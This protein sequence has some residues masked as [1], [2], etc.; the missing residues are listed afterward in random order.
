MDTIVRSF[1]SALLVAIVATSSLASGA[2]A[3]VQRP[4]MGTVAV[5]AIEDASDAVP[6]VEEIRAALIAF[7]APTIN[8]MDPLPSMPLGD[9]FD[10]SDRYV[11]VPTADSNEVTISVGAYNVDDG[12]DE[13][14]EFQTA[15]AEVQSY[16]QARGG[17]VGFAA[18]TAENSFGANESYD[19]VLISQQGDQDKNLMVVRLA[20]FGKTIV[21]VSTDT[22]LKA[23]PATDTDT[24]LMA[25]INVVISKLVADKA[26]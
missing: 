9:K 22:D 25:T 18:T 19:G 15:Y 20:R 12:A 21:Y 5:M 4:S 1:V 23:S 11:A 17:K 6:Y 13:R 8:E 14:A 3:H 7:G 16:A 24:T 26:R 10:D 2:S